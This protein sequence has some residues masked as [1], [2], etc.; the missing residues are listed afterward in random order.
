MVQL[1]LDEGADAAAKDENGETPRDAAS[2]RRLVGVEARFAR[3]PAAARARWAEHGGSG[4]KERPRSV[5][6]AKA[7]GNGYFGK[8]DSLAL[9][10]AVWAYTDALLLC[11]D[12]EAKAVLC[13]NRSAAHAKLLHFSAALGDAEAACELRPRWARAHGRRA[14]ALHGL[15]RY[16]EAAAGYV[17]ALELE[18]ASK[19]L[20]EGLRL[21]RAQLDGAAPK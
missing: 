10:R 3:G 9:T 13:S 12:D 1:L 2:R 4:V 7:A 18:P 17:G 20:E 6:E 8:G 5:D 16:E 21:V 19:P 11:E 14:A 15:G